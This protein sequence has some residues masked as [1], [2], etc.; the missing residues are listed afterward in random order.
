MPGT[1]QNVKITLRVGTNICL[2]SVLAGVIC[3]S[4][5]FVFVFFF[6]MT[7]ILKQELTC[8]LVTVIETY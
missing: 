5:V 1:A 3:D 8:D 2:V 6:D 4:R 7:D